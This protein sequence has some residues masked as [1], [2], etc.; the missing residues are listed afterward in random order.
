M[1]P[2]T[3]FSF[4][5]KN[6]FLIHLISKTNVEKSLILIYRRCCKLLRCFCSCI[7][8]HVA[9]FRANLELPICCPNKRAYTLAISVEAERSNLK[10]MKIDVV[11]IKKEVIKL[12]D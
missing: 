1:Y 2:I 3:F 10:Q 8:V 11:N 12:L 9:C 4:K 7:E 5:I 6:C